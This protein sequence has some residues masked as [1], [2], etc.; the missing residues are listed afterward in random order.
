MKPKQHRFV[1][2]VEAWT[3]LHAERALLLCFASRKPD[4]CL[5]TLRNYAAF[6]HNE[7][8]KA[9]RRLVESMR[10]PLP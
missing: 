4:G 6:A 10:K 7:R 3:K 5:F 8:R 1:V 2:T 9:E